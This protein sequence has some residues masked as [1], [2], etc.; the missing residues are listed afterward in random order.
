[1]KNSG[2]TE[3]AKQLRDGIV[4][5]GGDSKA[6]YDGSKVDGI[7]IDEDEVNGGEV[8]NEIEKKSQKTSKSN[9][10]FKSK[11]ALGSDFLTFGVRLAFTE[12]R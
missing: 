4:G 1:M 6:G 12:L 8:D 5:V 7:E 9:K 10:L 11:K 2:S 3:S